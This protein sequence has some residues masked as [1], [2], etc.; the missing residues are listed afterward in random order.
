MLVKHQG[1]EMELYSIPILGTALPSRFIWGFAGS[2]AVEV[3]TAYSTWDT[4][5][6]LSKKYKKFSFW[7]I[8]FLV[9]CVGGGLADA[10]GI[11][12]NH[13]LAA[14]IGASAPAIVHSFEGGIRKPSEPST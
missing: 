2:M 6:G 12:D 7:I 4:S 11:E 13:L 10:Y 3:M 14:N 5:K 9:A 8:R 1:A